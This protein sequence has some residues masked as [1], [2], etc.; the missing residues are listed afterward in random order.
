MEIWRTDSGWS[1]GVGDGLLRERR[2]RRCAAC[3]GGAVVVTDGEERAQL[4]G[5]GMV[6]VAAVADRQVSK[7]GGVGLLKS[8]AP[9]ALRKRLGDAPLDGV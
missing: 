3:R 4:D 9:K 1:V 5:V 8:S 2:L 7:A 6:G